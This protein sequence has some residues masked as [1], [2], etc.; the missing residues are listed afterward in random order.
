MSDGITVDIEGFLGWADDLEHE[1]LEAVE[2]GEGKAAIALLHDSQ[3][4]IPATPLDEG[5]LRG[6]GSVFVNNKLRATAPDIGGNPTP[7]TEDN[8]RI[9]RDT[10]VAIVGYNTPYAAYQHEGV[11]EDGTHQVENYSHS[12]TGAKFLEKAMAEN[13]DSYMAIVAAEVKK[14]TG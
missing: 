2:R 3:T 14:V 7:A 11:R 12:G 8:E 4:E 13:A 1:I 10:V 9:P 6:S 5:T